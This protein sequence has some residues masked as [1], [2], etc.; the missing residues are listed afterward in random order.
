M[1][2]SAVEKHFDAMARDFEKVKRKV[3]PGYRDIEKCILPY[4]PFTQ[5]RKIAVLELGTG[6]GA[7][8]RDLLQ[9][10]PR[11]NYTGIDFSSTM[12][13]LASHRLKKCDRRVTL[14]KADLNRI[15]IAGRYDLIISLFTIHH[16]I[17]KKGLFKHL[18]TLLKPGGCFLYGDALVSKNKRLEKC[19]IENWKDFMAQSGLSKRK[20]ERVIEDHRQYDHPEPLETQLHYLKTAGFKGYDVVWC[21]EKSGVFF[22]TK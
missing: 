5:S 15:K 14:H 2:K 16:I 1:G 12:L 20:R 21:R 19:F 7:L 13:E 3:I 8:A 9:Y 18:Y 17:N 4:L 10:Y 11:A 6:T 22:A